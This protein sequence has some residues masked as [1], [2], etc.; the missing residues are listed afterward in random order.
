MF[1]SAA[2]GPPGRVGRRLCRAG[3]HQPGAGA[4]VPADEPARAAVRRPARAPGRQHGGRPRR[5]GEAVRRPGLAAPSCQILPPGLPGYAP[6]CPFTHDLARPA[7]WS[8]ASGT[9]GQAVTLV[10]DTTAV[11]RAIGT[12]VLSVLQ[13]SG[14]RREAARAVGQRAVHLHPEHRQPRADQPDTLVRRLSRR[15]GLPAACCS[16]APPS[17]PAA[18]VRSTFPACAT[19]RWTPHAGSGRRRDPCGLG[20]RSTSAVTDP[21]PAAVLFNPRYIDVTSRRVQDF[22]T[23]EQYHWLMAQ[24]LGAVVAGGPVAAAA[25]GGARRWCCWRS[26]LACAAGAARTRRGWPGPTRSAPTSRAPS[27]AAGRTWPCWRRTPP[28]LGLGATPIGPGWGGAY[29][30]GRRRAGAGRGG[31]AAVW[32]PHLPADRGRG[33]R[34]SRWCWPAASA[35]WPGR[36]AAAWMPCCAGCWIWSGRSRS[37]CWRS[38]SRAV[39]ASS[40]CGSGR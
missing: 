3:A 17:I 37:S 22:P 29:P 18:T 31:P 33:H 26:S 27:C 19:R 2:A 34:W 12:Y 9:A 36:P 21:A 16:A 1:D 32:R 25:A 11:Q 13:Q 39:L 40:G 5:R 38:R 23:I 4:L 24:A 10:I 14:L 28:G 20:P 6:Y 8:R 7:P 35:C 15:D 30:A